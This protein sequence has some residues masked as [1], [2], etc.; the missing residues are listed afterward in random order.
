MQKHIALIFGALMIITGAAQSQS[1]SPYMGGEV[2]LIEL[3]NGGVINKNAPELADQ[4][5]T[6]EPKIVNIAEGIWSIEGFAHV[7]CAVIEGETTL[8]VYDTGNENADGQ[9]FLDA[10]RQVSDKPIKTVIYSHA[11]YVWGTKPMLE[12]AEDY[13]VIGH[14]NLN[15]NILESSGLGS[16]IPELAPVLTARAYEQFDVYN[17]S[18]GPDA[19]LASSPVGSGEKGFVAVTHPV[20][21]GQEM[22]VD[23][24]KMQFFTDYHSDT[25]DCLLVYFPD[26]GLVLNNLYWP[27][28]GNL[29]TLRGSLYRDPIP[30]MEGLRLIR[31]LKPEHLIST[32]T[33]AISGRDEIFEAITNYHDGLAYLYDQTLRHILLGDSPD[34]MR[35]NIELPEHLASWPNNQETYGELSYYPPNIYNYAL[36][37][38][39]GNATNLNKVHPD[40]EAQKIVEGFGGKEEVMEQVKKALMDQEFSWATQLSDYLYKVYPNDQEV[41]QL[42]ADALRKMG[43]LTQASI[44]RSWYLSQ[45]RAL[46]GKVDILH[47]VMPSVEQILDSD[48]GTYVNMMRVRI[49]P[50]LSIE[51]DKVIAFKFTDV[52]ENATHGLHVRKGVAEYIS[53]PADYYRSA[54]VTIELPRESFAKYYAGDLNLEQLLDSELVSVTGSRQEAIEL[55]SQFD[56]IDP[57][58]QQFKFQ[59]NEV[60]KTTQIN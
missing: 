6:H 32:H 41:R 38:Y 35:H 47:A 9:K 56:Q 60:D 40:L 23:G 54:D 19:P 53:K 51:T 42:K 10:I 28:Y 8:I 4:T 37:W 14:P 22:I 57:S 15:K 11:H 2:E 21:N 39:D 34:E 16:S 3:P 58:N 48:P 26:K 13:M 24:V 31:D 7:N 30:W 59:K 12:G 52:E 18:E 46:E 5:W 29:Y 43:Q 44:P 17:P 1:K 20:S 33:Y 50:E 36:G 45:A 27:I 55:L 49:D 25:D